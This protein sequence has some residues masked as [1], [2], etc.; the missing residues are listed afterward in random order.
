MENIAILDVV[1]ETTGD[2]LSLDS[3]FS[4]LEKA[5]VPNLPIPATV[6]PPQKESVFVR[7][8]NRIKVMYYANN[9]IK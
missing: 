3:L 4:E 9:F 7:L 1:D 6:S 5:V 2:P 8:A